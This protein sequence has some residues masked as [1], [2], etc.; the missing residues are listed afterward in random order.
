MSSKR[1]LFIFVTGVILIAIA[2]FYR[3][4]TVLASEAVLQSRLQVAF[5]MGSTKAQ[6]Q[7]YANQEGW[8][9]FVSS[10]G[11]FER[12][13]PAKDFIPNNTLGWEMGRYSIRQNTKVLAEFEFDQSNRLYDIRVTKAF[14]E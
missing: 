7:A 9:N 6:V 2:Q 3:T 13:G 5:P 14:T 12:I 8:S 11:V 1:F 4:R 10:E